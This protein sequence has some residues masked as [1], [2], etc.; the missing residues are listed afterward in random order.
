M[1]YV[2]LQHELLCDFLSPNISMLWNNLVILSLMTSLNDQ[3]WIDIFDFFL[4]PCIRKAKGRDLYLGF[5]Y[6][7][8]T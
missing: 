1:Q 4:I 2:C 3:G 7:L 8:E 6:N 5:H